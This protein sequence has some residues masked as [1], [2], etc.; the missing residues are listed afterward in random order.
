M[1]KPVEYVRGFGGYSFDSN[2]FTAEF[3]TEH[4]YLEALRDDLEQ[5]FDEQNLRI[6]RESVADG[7]T[8]LRTN[9]YRDWLL[10]S[11]HAGAGQFAAG[12]GAPLYDALLQMLTIFTGLNQD[13]TRRPGVDLYS[14][15]W[16]KGASGVN[17]NSSFFG[18]VIQSFTIEQFKTYGGE[19]VQ[20]KG[21]PEQ[22]AQKASNQIAISVINDIV[23]SNYTLPDIMGLG[24]ADAGAVASDVFNIEGTPSAGGNYAP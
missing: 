6:F 9:A 17:T 3:Q 13:P 1:N 5:L 10:N 12:L 15:E 18:Q 23:D 19:G 14:Y 24:V 20:G 21:S 8:T 22:E 4:A 16:I 7:Q 11:D 2:D